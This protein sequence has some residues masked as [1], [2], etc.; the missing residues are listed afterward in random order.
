M[1]DLLGI[2]ART[3]EVRW[4]FES[5]IS[6]GGVPRS[7]GERIFVSGSTIGD[8]GQ[9]GHLIAIDLRTGEEIWS[10]ELEDV[11]T[12]PE[13]GDGAVYMAGPVG[14]IYAFDAATG[15]ELWRNRIDAEFGAPLRAEGG[16]LFTQFSEARYPAGVVVLARLDAATGQELW[17]F[18]TAEIG[19]IS[20]MA[21]PVGEGAVYLFAGRDVLMALDVETGQQRWAATVP[22]GDM[23]YDD[24]T[25]FVAHFS[26]P[27]HVVEAFAAATGIP[28]WQRPVAGENG[29]LVSVS[30]DTIYVLG[31]P[32]ST[33]ED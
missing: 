26:H 29:A 25:V 3:G 14:D 17:R 28:L 31:A 18:E 5:G 6:L 21:H 32:E 22:E 1:N 15:D 30:E 7:D 13:V 24:G 10:I 20:R 8:S 16:M 33:Y 27:Q 12:I 23:V 4:R 9:L 19:I 11:S 2:D